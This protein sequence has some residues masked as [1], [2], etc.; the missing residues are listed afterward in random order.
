LELHYR[1]AEAAEWQWRRTDTT[2]SESWA[3]SQVERHHWSQPIYKS[4]W[5]HRKSPLLRDDVLE[6]HWRSV[7][8]RME[9]TQIVLL[10]IK[11][12]M[13]W[14]NFIKALWQDNLKSI[15]QL[16][17]SGSSITDCTQEAMS[18]DGAKN[19]PPAQ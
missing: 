18:R 10:Q 15:R 11:V 8:G 19:M 4:Y 14:Q 12:R 17:Q 6:C 1:K 3:I 7:D 2:G 13:Y 16:I 5:A 9:V